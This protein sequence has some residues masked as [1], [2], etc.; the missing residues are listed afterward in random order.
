[1]FGLTFHSLWGAVL[2]G[3]RVST[4]SQ[5]CFAKQFQMTFIRT[6]SLDGTLDLI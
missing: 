4:D 5:K 2:Q 1:M 6:Q 3:R